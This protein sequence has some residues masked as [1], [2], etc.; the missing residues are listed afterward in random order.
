MRRLFASTRT[1]F[2][3]S[4]LRPEL[5]KAEM[6]LKAPSHLLQNISKTIA[7]WDGKTYQGLMPFSLAV[8]VLW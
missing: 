7:S 5:L 2:A 4:R 8:D 6:A 3:S 1:M